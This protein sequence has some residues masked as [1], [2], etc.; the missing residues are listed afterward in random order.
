MQSDKFQQKLMADLLTVVRQVLEDGEV[1]H[2][3]VVDALTNMSAKQKV[4]FCLENG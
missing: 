2:E 4:C 1:R 3:E